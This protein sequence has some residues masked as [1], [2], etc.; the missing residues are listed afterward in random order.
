MLAEP[1]EILFEAGDSKV[2][3]TIYRRVLIVAGERSEA[4]V[5]ETYV[6][7]G[8]TFTNAVTEIALFP[9]AILE[10]TKLQDEGLE[11][12]HVHALAAIQSRSP[13][14]IRSNFD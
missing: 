5:V 8:R 13:L 10:H 9:G 12:R 7:A 3:E 11:A 2:P 1:I 14:R 4:A 6:G